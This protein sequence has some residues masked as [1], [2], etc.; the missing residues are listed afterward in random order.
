MVRVSESRSDELGKASF[1]MSP[2]LT[3]LLFTGSK[4]SRRIWYHA[5]P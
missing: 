4:G 1:V 3:S 5:K 2:F